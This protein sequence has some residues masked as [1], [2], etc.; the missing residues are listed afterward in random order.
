MVSG[1]EGRE[2]EKRGGR[3]VEGGGPLIFMVGGRAGVR[4][5]VR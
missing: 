3:E 1:K 5:E 4:G 2:R